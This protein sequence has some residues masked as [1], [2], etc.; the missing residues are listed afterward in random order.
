MHSEDKAIWTFVSCF[1][2]S[3]I[4][5]C[6]FSGCSYNLT[7]FDFSKIAFLIIS[8]LSKNEK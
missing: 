1:G 2:H 5:A 4:P 3:V 6:Q 7:L 8:I